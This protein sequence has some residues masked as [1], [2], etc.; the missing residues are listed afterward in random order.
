MHAYVGD[1][2]AEDKPAPAELTA[3]E[4][5][6][7]DIAA[8]GLGF[9]HF[10]NPELAAKRLAERLKP[11]GVLLILDFLPHGEM[12]H[13]HPATKTVMH[14]GFSAERVRRI[15]EDAGVGK[16]YAIEEVGDVSFRGHEDK[17]K[18]FMARGTKA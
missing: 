1:L 14:H 16:D 6:D 5:Y 9:H 17:R 7:F 10:D 12:E 2:T 13:S 8:V 3:P 11:G 15:F 4:F 18:L